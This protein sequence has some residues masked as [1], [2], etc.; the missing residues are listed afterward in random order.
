MKN[1]L[2]K[3]AEFYFRRDRGITG[4]RSNRSGRGNRSSRGVSLLVLSLISFLSVSHVVFAAPPANFQVQQLVTQGLDG[5]SGLGIAP[6]GRIFILERTGKI[7]IYKNGQLLATPFADLPSAGSGDRGLIGVAFDPEFSTNHFVYF[8]YTSATDLLNYLVRFNA[9]GD[10]GTDGPT[11]LYQTHSPSNQLHVGGSIQFGPDGKLYFAIGDNGYPPNAQNLANPHGKILRINKDGTIPNDNPFVGQPGAVPEIWAYGFRNPWRFQFDSTNGKVYLSDVGNDAWEEIN[12]LEK[13]KNYGWPVCEGNCANPD[14]MNPLYTYPHNGASS[15][16]TGGPVYRSTMFPE[17]YQGRLFFGDYARGFLKTMGLDADGNSTGVEDFDTNVGSIVDLKVA[18]DGSMYYIDYYPG[19]LYRLSYAEGNQQPVAVAGSDLTKGLPPLTVNFTSAG[20]YDPDGSP[21]TYH[22][23]FGDG[24]ATDSA[25]QV[26]TKTYDT[27]GTYLVDMTV[28]DGTATAQAVPITVQVGIPPTV[29]IGQPTNGSLYQA[30]DVFNYTVHAIDGVGN[31]INDSAIQTEVIFHHGTHIH[32]FLGPITGRTGSFTTPTSGETSA[33]TWFEIRAKATDTNGLATTASVFLY[34]KKVNITVLSNPSGM[35]LLLDGQPITTPYTFQ[36]V[37]N[38][39]REISTLT[40]QILGQNSYDF[41]AWSDSGARTHILMTPDT[42]QVITANFT[43]GQANYFQGQYFNS[44]DLSGTPVFTRADQSINF[45]WGDGSPDPSVNVDFFSVR[46]TKTD[47]FAP[48]I[49]HFTTSTDDGVRLKIDG[50]TVIDKWQDQSALTYAADVPLAAGN[51]TIVMEY[52]EH[53]AGAVAKMSYEKTAELPSAPGFTAEYFDNQ[54][55]SGT[56][57]KTRN[58]DAI[59]FDWHGGSPDPIIPVDH[60]SARWTKTIAFENSTYRFSIAAD[61]GLRIFL[62]GTKIFDHWND[63]SAT[64]TF[65]QNISQGN[66]DLKVEYFENGGDAKAKVSWEKITNSVDSGFTAQYYD[67]QT[68]SGLP[69]MVRND[70]AINFDWGNSS[71]DTSLPPDHFSVRWTKT[72]NFAPGTYRFTTT[73]DD[74]VRLK[75]DGTTHI[76]KWIDQSSKQYQ[77]DVV[78]EGGEHTIVMEYYENGGGAVAKL[79]WEIVGDVPTTDIQAQYFGN[80]NLSGAPVLSKTESAINFDW[81]ERSP[82]PL[83]PTDNF[84]ARY[85]K[86]ESFAGG[87]YRFVITADD[88]IRVF[89]DGVSLLDQ[90]K[91]QSPTTYTVFSTIQAGTHTVVVEYYEKGGGAVAKTSWSRVSGPSSQGFTA[92]Y[93]NNRFL[94]GLPTINR[95][96]PSITFNW[97]QG[98]PDQSIANDNF[99][100]RWL[101]TEHFVGGTYTFTTMSDDGIRV[102]VDDAIIIDKWQ[103]QSSKT[104]NVSLPIADG[105]H[106]VKVEY[107][108]NGGDAVA[109]VSWESTQ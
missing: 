22:W 102:Y 106:T 53:S 41:D 107:Y 99:S 69:A 86:T 54:N 70:A 63:Q 39:Q 87:E 83:V 23:N 82:D 30:G 4:G 80:P 27:K 96:D 78:L 94:A 79:S 105:D 19:R 56:P 46:W 91:D 21:L 43:Q 103:D 75:I 62:D 45:N 98:S 60:F 47:T 90:W 17:H 42:D 5:P 25:Q 40:P 88:G 93:F 15:S 81:G 84:S 34:P 44:I 65:D 13:G 97:G 31:D 11:I 59:D 92:S 36:G 49:Y 104:Y 61:D 52:Y 33:D 67:N 74:G 2:K 55:L 32:P 100:A 18:P 38:F 73:S 1:I 9:E 108:E 37:V 29:T 35:Q 64:F 71:P 3:L 8:Y 50:T 66:H 77:T 16:V 24:S 14:F 95:I 72:Q 12:R 20:S 51:H 57:I 48:G 68:M 28:S 26:V 76:D 109:N 89:I 101:K 58:D 7:K 10:V 6:D 85:K